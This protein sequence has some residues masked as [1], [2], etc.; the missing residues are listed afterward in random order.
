MPYICGRVEKKLH[1]FL[2]ATLDRG[3]LLT[4]CPSQIKVPEVPAGYETG[5]GTE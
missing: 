5:W 4:S 1:A 2:T 3:K